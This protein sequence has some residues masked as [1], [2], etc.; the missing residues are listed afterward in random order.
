MS[1]PWYRAPAQP[2][3]FADARRHLPPGQASHALEVFKKT[4]AAYPATSQTQ[5][6]IYLP[7]SAT[8]TSAASLE[9]LKYITKGTTGFDRDRRTW[10]AGRG[11][12]ISLIRWQIVTG[13]KELALAA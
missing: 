13:E 4:G 12:I 9:V 3:C 7:A 2:G 8:R 5:D 10:I 11:A 6:A 1:L